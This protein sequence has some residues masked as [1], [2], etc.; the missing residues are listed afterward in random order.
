[1]ATG[2]ITENKVTYYLNKNDQ[3][4]AYKKG[5]TYYK[6]N[7]TKMT[8][9][10]KDD[11]V[12]LRRAR[13]IV[14]KITT[15]SM[16]KSQKLKKCFDWVMAFPYKRQRYFPRGDKAWASLYAN[17]HFVRKAGDCH[18]DAAALGYLAR[19]IGYTDVYVCLDAP[20][21]N[22]GHHAWTKIDGLNYD[23]LFAQAK[24]YSKYYGNK[25]YELNAIVKDKVGIGYLGDA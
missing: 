3:V 14:R 4:E 10:E 17:D 6:P 15:S 23:P 1:M 12:T 8:S 19:A 16:S 20:L 24:N 21:S 22:A 7:G 13:D 25:S 2:D 11:Y 9:M 18:A 5:S